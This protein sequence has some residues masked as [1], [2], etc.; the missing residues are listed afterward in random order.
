MKKIILISLSLIISFFFLELFLRYIG[1]KNFTLYY[2]S[3][4][5]GYYH[6]PNQNFLSR[7]DKKISFDNLGNRNSKE[8][9]IN[10]SEIFFLGDSVTY[11]GSIVTNNETFAFIISERLNKKYLNI[12]A[13][14]WGIPNIINFIEFH[15]LYKSNS[16]YI[17]TC[18]SDCF[19]RNLRRSEQN[20]F[21]KNNS[22][23]ALINFYKFI[24]FKINQFNYLPDL[25][26]KTAAEVKEKELSTIKDN[27]LTIDY[28][29]KKLASFNQN[30][31][32][33]NSRLIF[34]YSPNINY[35]KSV[36]SYDTLGL[37]T[38]YKK[39][40]EEILNKVNENDIE[41]I[42]ILEY[43]DEKTI[44]NFGKFY[45]DSVHLTKDGHRLYSKILSKLIYE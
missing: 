10:N 29:V 41:T 42:N 25:S 8:N 33:I 5:Y 9:N 16:V 24:I 30:L 43:F 14:G 31:K 38:I 3:N 19:T 28:S 15:N 12:S 32:K 40:R 6:Q 39:Y 1:F 21:F 13:N 23:F 34:V 27:I 37:E 45:I 35:I 17:L 7:F 18:I 44:Y 26:G 22:K 11:G 20:F 2:P 4:Y 36:L